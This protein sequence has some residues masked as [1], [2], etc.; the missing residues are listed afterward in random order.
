MLFSVGNY[1]NCLGMLFVRLSA[2]RS[3]GSLFHTLQYLR[4]WDARRK[5]KARTTSVLVIAMLF[6]ST[7]YALCISL[8]MCLENEPRNIG[9]FTRQYPMLSLAVM[10]LTRLTDITAVPFALSYVV[11]VGQELIQIHGCLRVSTRDSELATCER[12]R[13]DLK[14]QFKLLTKFLRVFTKWTKWYSASACN[15]AVA[16]LQVIAIATTGGK[17]GPDYFFYGFSN[18]NPS[19]LLMYVGRGMG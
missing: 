19:T 16:W 1:V 13:R 14:L 15:N 10:L 3:W 8:K 6:V 9:G 18:I 11:V 5:Q 12:K 2:A 17:I 4:T 7:L